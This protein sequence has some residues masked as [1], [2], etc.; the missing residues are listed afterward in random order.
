MQFSYHE[1]GVVHVLVTGGA[2]YIGSH[3]ALR[4]L[5]DS[6]RVTIVVKKAFSLS[7]RQALLRVNIITLLHFSNLKSPFTG[8]SFSRKY[9]SC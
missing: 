3:A 6:Y 4:L 8:Q 7:Y 9:R 2:G 1:E 5:R